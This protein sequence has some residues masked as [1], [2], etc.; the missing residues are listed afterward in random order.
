[1]KKYMLF[2]AL[3]L[4]FPLLK[5]QAGPCKNRFAQSIEECRALESWTRNSFTP[6]ENLDQQRKFQILFHSITGFGWSGETNPRPGSFNEKLLNDPSLIASNPKISAS[7]ISE[8]KHKTFRGY[9]G[10][11]LEVNPENLV[12]TSFEDAGSPPARSFNDD[13]MYMLELFSQSK[14][15]DIKTPKVIIDLT[16]RYNEIVLTGTD[17]I[18]KHQVKPVGVVVRCSTTQMT[19]LDHLRGGELERFLKTKCSPFAP[20]VLIA[21]QKLAG[22]YP[23]F[24]YPLE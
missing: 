11:I 3:L 13:E 19:R 18:S 16:E 17:Q 24:G 10:F 14:K 15:V 20:E 5:A 2:L 22:M 7:V 1:M 6:V 23:V 4:S 12:A 8:T 21:I 9:L